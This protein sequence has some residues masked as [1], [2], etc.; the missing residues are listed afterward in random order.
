MQDITTILQFVKFLNTFRDLKRKIHFSHDTIPEDDAQH[1]WQLAV[2]SWYI[3]AYKKWPLSIEKCL[4]FALVHDLVELYAGDVDAIYRTAEDQVHKIE[5]EKA[6]LT[7]LIHDYPDAQALWD[8]LIEYEACE[9]EEAIFIYS[10]D[11]IL[12]SMNIANDRGYEWKMRNHS[13]HDIISM[14][15]SKVMKSPYGGEIRVE[16]KQFLADHKDTIF[17]LQPTL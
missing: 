13:M 1:S 16:L 17:S 5:A 12:A 8:I 2:V 14:K 15:E 11:K 9:S 4:Q 6:A 3:I 10:L 7:K